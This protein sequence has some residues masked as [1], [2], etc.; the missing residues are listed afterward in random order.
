MG[1]VLAAAVTATAMR[2]IQRAFTY[3]LDVTRRRGKGR[4]EERA[5]PTRA[6]TRASLLQHEDQCHM[7][8]LAGRD[9]AVTF[10]KTYGTVPTYDIMTW[11]AKVR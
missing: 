1:R 7:M 3:T 4:G 11:Q 10:D 2:V 6:T 5:G 9:A 8:D